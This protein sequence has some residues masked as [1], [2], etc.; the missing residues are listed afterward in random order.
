MARSLEAAQAT[1]RNNAPSSSSP[2]PS[3]SSFNYTSQDYPGKCRH[4][5]KTPENL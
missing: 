5:E 4:F 2:G 3:T 1:P